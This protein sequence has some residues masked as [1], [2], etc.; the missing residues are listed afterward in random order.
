MLFDCGKN[1]PLFFQFYLTIKHKILLKEL[2]PG[3]RIETLEELVEKYQVSHTTVRRALDLL[4]RDGM[5]IRKRGAGTFVRQDVDLVDW[6]STDK[7]PENF[8][9][10]ATPF[11]ITPLRQEWIEPPLRIRNAFAGQK[12]VFDNGL[13]FKVSRLLTDS[14][15]YRKKA[16]IDRYVPAWIIKKI[17][18]D[19]INTLN[20]PGLLSRSRGPGNI[21]GKQIIRPWLCDEESG[22]LLGLAGGTPVFQRTWFYYEKENVNLIVGEGLNN[23]NAFILDNEIKVK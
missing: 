10:I 22:R 1:I 3:S 15:D 19:E 17:D 14:T 12:N 23:M 7:L 8:Q 20:V 4:E 21:R 2:P 13:V 11:I 9:L 6:Y 18:P 16:V 5:L